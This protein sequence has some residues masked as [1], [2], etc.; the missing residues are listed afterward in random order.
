MNELAAIVEGQT[1]ATFVREILA[2]HLSNHGVSMWARLPGR[3]V[4]RGGVKPWE[5]ICSDIVR[6]LR[7][8]DSRNCTT[9]FDYYGMPLDWPG[10]SGAQALAWEHRGAFVEDALL[11]DIANRMGRSFRRERFIPYVQVHEFEAVLFS[12][13]SEFGQVL[14]KV[15]G[16]TT[17]FL[18]RALN[19]ILESAGA[20]EA[21]N[22]DPRTAPSKR[23]LA[24]ATGYRKELHGLIAAKRIGLSS[25]RERC[26]HFGEWLSRLESLGAR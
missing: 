7:E 18:E 5:S 16:T 2:P 22:D 17:V 8:R 24:L 13:V 15:P 23:V 20:P 1:E 10:R 12:S 3:F 6:T 25:M 14:M 21:I 4:R 11:D 9:M 19:E 26:G